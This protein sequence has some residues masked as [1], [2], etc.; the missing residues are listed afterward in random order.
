MRKKSDFDNRIKIINE[1]KANYYFS[2]HLNYLENS[3][4]FGPQV[5]YNNQTKNNKIIAEHIQKNLNQALKTDREVKKIPSKT[6]MYD[7]L[8]IDGVLIE[9]GFLSNPQER[10]LLK[11]KDYQKKFAK[12]LAKSIGELST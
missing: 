1:S 3:K 7:K 8:K 4:Y 11:S 2:I 6:Y 5:F 9:C 10:N 12:I